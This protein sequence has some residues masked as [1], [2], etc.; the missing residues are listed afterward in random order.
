VI[1]R[2]L[3]LVGGELVERLGGPLGEDSRAA[4]RE[5]STAAQRASWIAAAQAPIPPG[6]RGVHPSW[7]EAALAGLP[8]RA[9]AAFAGGAA[10][11]LEVWL[12]RW[13]CA[14]LPPLPALR[15]IGDPRS[16]GDVVAMAQL[17]VW[18]DAVG[19]AQ[20]AYAAS[21]A[22][23]GAPRRDELGPARV[24]IARCRGGDATTIAA[25]ALAPHCD[26]IA[27]RQLAVRLPREI[28]IAI[29]CEL[30]AHARDPVAHAPA[31]HALR[32]VAM[33]P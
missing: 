15:E 27:A 30:L 2:V 18:L 5:G 7:I 12:V 6:L 19:R 13:A 29:E 32:S 11:A 8:E 31:W 14:E 9:R 20:L 1:A 24:V 4:A 16:I 17:A 33:L 10:G 3:A 23:P 22:H 21:L 26:A 28:G 25:R